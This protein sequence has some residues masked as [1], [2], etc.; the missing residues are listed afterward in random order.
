MKQTIGQFLATL[1]RER[2]MTQAEVA[3]RLG[4]SDRT[5]SSW[6][7][8]A[9]YPDILALPELA[10]LYGVTTDEILRG[11]KFS[12]DEEAPSK[13]TGIPAEKTEAPKDDAE[14]TE[15]K[16]APLGNYPVWACAVLGFVFAACACIALGAYNYYGAEAGWGQPVYAVGWVLLGV[17]TALLLAVFLGARSAAEEPLP[18]ARGVFLFASVFALLLFLTGIGCLIGLL[19]DDSVVL[20][21]TGGTL[22]CVSLL[23]AVCSAVRYGRLRARYGE[24]QRVRR[25]LRLLLRVGGIGMAPLVVSL[26]VLITF[27]FVKPQRQDIVYTAESFEEF[28]EYAESIDSRGNAYH[29]MC[30]L[31]EGEYFLDITRRLEAGEGERVFNAATGEEEVVLTLEGGFT[32]RIRKDGESCGLSFTAENGEEGWLTGAPRVKMQEG[33]FYALRFERP[34]YSHHPDYGSP[35]FTGEGMS[36]Y[37]DEEGHYVALNYAD[38]DYSPLTNALCGVAI[39]ADVFICAAVVLVKRREV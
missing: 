18:L 25:E 24:G 9:R 14:R 31:A 29:F 36:Y 20:G 8:D 5:L 3:E 21:A 6:E 17:C 37:K 1:R 15:K 34:A 26:A 16:A 30:G 32:A 38:F 10:A 13:T 23:L 19:G 35:F 12:D 28:A 39:A 27:W 2:G 22:L 33:T 11:E 7:R 4:I